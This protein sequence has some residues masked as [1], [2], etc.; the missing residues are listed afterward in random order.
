M[1][2]DLPLQQILG[3][4]LLVAGIGYGGASQL[5]KLWRRFKPT[6]TAPGDAGH[7]TDAAP[8]DGFREHVAVILNAAPHAPSE[9]LVSYCGI[10]MTEAEVLVS[11]RDRLQGLVKGA[12]G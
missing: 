10:G 8:P 1:T 4:V 3:I 7:N 11:E 12:E 6:A 9:T 2:V 5:P